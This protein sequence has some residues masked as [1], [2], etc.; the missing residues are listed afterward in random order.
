MKFLSLKT[1]HMGLALLILLIAAGLRIHNLNA[2]GLW[3]DEAFSVRFSDPVNPLEITE[4]LVD[5]LHPPLYF[6]ILGSWRELVGSSEVA[7]RLLAVYAAILSV[8]L[9]I[10]IGRKL[11]SAE[12]GIFAGLILA[13]ADKHI[14]LSQEVRHYPMAFMLMAASSLVY[15]FWLDK[16]TRKRTLLYGGLMVISVYTHYYTTLIL[17]AQVVYALLFLRPWTRVRDLCIIMGIANLTFLPW[18]PIAYHQIEIRPEGILH[19]YSRSWATLEFFTLDFL[20]RP[21]PLFLALIVLGVSIL[22]RANKRWRIRIFQHPTVWYAVLWLVLPVGLAVAVFDYVTLLT[23]RNMAL[24]ILPLALL[25]GHGIASF[26]PPASTILAV[27]IL[28]NGVTSLDSYFDHPPWR[29]LAHYVAENYPEG[30][31]IVMDVQGGHTALGFYLHTYLPE[32]T[33]IISLHEWRYNQPDEFDTLLDDFLNRHTGFWVAYW[34]DATYALEQVYQ[35]HGYTRTASHTEYHLGFPIIWYHYDK[36]PPVSERI[37][38]YDGKISLHQM[39]A[40]GAGQIGGTLTVSLWWST[41]EPLAT[42]YSISTFL[43]NDNGILRAQHDGAP[44]DGDQPTNTW[45]P[46]EIIFDTHRIS[47]PPDLPAGEYRLA[48]K[49]YNSADGTI[50]PAEGENSI[51]NEYLIVGTVRVR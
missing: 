17:M 19:S 11:F 34:G 45:Q 38:S 46:D 22:Q 47:I 27:M 32:D 20:G 37:G 3:G 49:V 35:A 1:R 40:P 23:D 16:P 44:Q 31:P 5:D 39:K 42:S 50:L 29:E 18:L 6:I 13:I 7:M 36:V 10:R 4:R 43:L 28:A 41:A 25:I 14:L 12:A 24:V 8:A 51:N 26:R 9:V 15:L 21:V 30:E 48:V 33:E 2:Q